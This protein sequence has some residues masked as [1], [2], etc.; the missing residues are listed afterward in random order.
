VSLHRRPVRAVLAALVV[1]VAASLVVAAGTPAQAINTY[2]SRPSHRAEVGTLVVEFFDDATQGW[3]VDWECSGT[4]VDRDTF[5]TAAH[6][7]TD[8][9]SRPPRFLVSLDADVEGALAPLRDQGGLTHAQADAVVAALDSTAGYQGVHAVVGTEHH[10]AAYPGPSS[11]PHD[12]AVVEVPAVRVAAHWTFTPARLPTAGLLSAL[13]SRT[14]ETRTWTVAGYG[15]SEGTKGPGGHTYPNGGVRLEATV[16][17][18]ALTKS[19]VRLAMN[20]SRGYGGACY[21][22]SGGPNF[23]RVGGTDVLAA[24]TVTGDTPCYATNV[25]YRTDT[26]TA[27]AFLAPYVALP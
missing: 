26:P 21:G 16:G 18:N 13:G 5:L 2:N 7:V 24:L 11:N 8:W 14:L 3:R 20:V 4:M 17:F 23:V 15:E 6:C 10:D 27:C 9:G 1:A 12:I 22:D 19:W 25:A